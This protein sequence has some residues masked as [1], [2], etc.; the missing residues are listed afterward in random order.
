MFSL[1]VVLAAGC[2]P[3]EA[4]AVPEPICRQP[5]TT[6]SGD[7]FTEVTEEVG[8][9]SAATSEPVATSVVAG[10]VDGD[11]WVDFFA[12]LFPSQREPDPA[13]RTR[14]LFM[15]RPDPADPSRRVFLDALEESGLLTTR[16]GEGGRGITTV[17]WGDLDADGDLDAVGCPAE[18]SPTIVDGC[19]A[20]LNDGSAH[21]VLAD[22]GALEDDVF[23]VPST[24]LLDYDRDG[25]LDL[26]PAT[27]GNWQYGPAATSS[28]RLY[29]GTG[30]G[31]F[32]E[33]S[34]RVGLPDDLST[35]DDYRMNFGLTACDYDLDGDQD[36]LVANYGVPIGPNRVYRNDEG[37]FV[38]VAAELGVERADLG[39]FTF[40]IT[41]GDLDADGD[42]DLM[43]A[44]VAHPGQGTDPSAL[45][46]SSGDPNA[47]YARA[48]S[49]SIGMDRPAGD[50]EGDN[51]AFFA[52][53]D[54]DGRQDVLVLSS[55]YPQQSESDGEYSR[56]YLFRQTG[57]L[58]FEDVS[59]RTP[60]SRPKH[61]TLEGGALAD[62]DNDGDLDFI[63]GK[64]LFNSTW[65]A[66]NLGIT[67]AAIQVYRNEVGQ[68][69]NWTQVRLVG[70]GPGAS[71]RS[72]L[73][74]RVTVTAGGRQQSQEVFGSWGHSN[75]Q[76]DVTLTFGLGDSCTI[77]ELEVRWP[78]AAGTV[79]TYADVLAN[80]PITLTEGDP[81]VEYTER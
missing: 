24:V 64:G 5:G 16:D 59:D 20:F 2:S 13:T 51:L 30:D 23:S 41:C 31:S 11:G 19:A 58:V 9:G 27:I 68:D 50:M 63:V 71:N 77:D 28:P 14:F 26:W 78:D 70:A 48:D 75:T 43:T 72:G 52:D 61:Q 44:E 66:E 62:I 34:Q 21:F 38:D 6:P 55:N 49:A 36:V 8:L 73:G 3:D 33:V 1:L 53:I 60:F 42:V 37:D 32:R 22:G 10:D 54:L 67:S 76:S 39:G 69:A 57:D 25:V 47:P 81:Q 18:I 35:P 15:N 40:S 4:G 79:T 7:W 65:I 17:S 12:S 56:P 80:Y 45:L 74:A 29:Q 46:V